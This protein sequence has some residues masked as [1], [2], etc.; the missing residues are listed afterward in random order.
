MADIYKRT[1]NR[2]YNNL[3][4]G[5]NNLIKDKPELIKNRPELE[6]EI[7]LKMMYIE[8]YRW[9]RQQVSDGWILNNQKIKEYK[10]HVDIRSLLE[11][12][13]E[14]RLYDLI[15]IIISINQ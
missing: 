8:H 9:I 4:K 11:I 12:N 7:L 3:I 10:Y 13:K 5:Y 1:T 2:C 6:N 15:N 14:K